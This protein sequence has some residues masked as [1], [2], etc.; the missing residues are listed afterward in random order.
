MTCECRKMLWDPFRGDSQTFQGGGLVS[1]RPPG[2]EKA[3]TV[4]V[5]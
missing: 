3:E 5:S 1:L 2:F 4:P